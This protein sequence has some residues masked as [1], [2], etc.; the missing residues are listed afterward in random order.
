MSLRQLDSLFRPRSVAVIG[1][2][3]RPGSIGS[4]VMHNMLRGGLPG[5]ILPVNPRYE[6]VSGV[7]AYPGVQE[8]PLVPDLALVCTPPG[9]VPGFVQELG[10]KGTKTA[11][12]MSRDLNRRQD[13]AGRTLQQ[14]VTETAYRHSM[15]I[16]GPDCLG[17]IVPRS[18]LNASFGHTDIAQGKIAFVSQSDA[19]G[20]A[21]LDWAGSKGIGF[22][23]FISLGDCLDVD[24][25]DIIDYLKGDPHSTSILLYMESIR[26]ARRFI[27]AAR[28]ASRNKPLVVIKGDKFSV[29]AGG[30]ASYMDSPVSTD[31]IYD[32]VFR[33]AG[34]LRVFDLAEL[35]D[36]V[37]AMAGYKPLRGDR[38]AILSNGGGPAMMARDV[39]KARGGR[40]AQ[41]SDQTRQ[42]LQQGLQAELSH[43]E[44]VRIID[45]ASSETYSR[46]LEVLIQDQSVDAIMV[47][48][49][50][51]AFACSQ[52]IA[53]AVINSLGRTRKNV[54]AVWLGEKDAAQARRMFALAGI[55]TYE[56]PDQAAR[57]F[58]DMVR[59]R[60]N[61]ELLMETPD[62]VP[63]EFIP[64]SR[65]AGTIVRNALDENRNCLSAPETNEVLSIYNIPVVATRQAADAQE[66]SLISRE[67]GFPLALKI[68]SPDI[69][70]KKHSGALALDLETSGDVLKAARA[71]Q[72][73][74]AAGC[75]E[76]SL[77]GFIVQKMVRRPTAHELTAGVIQ[78]PVFGPAI[79]FGLGNTA[80]KIFNDVAVGLP[81]LNMALAGEIIKQTRISGLLAGRGNRPAI[82]MQ[83]VRLILVQL[84]HLVIDLPEIQEVILKTIL[85]DAG[86]AVV[87]DARIS[88]ASA[89]FAGE[90]RL[91]IRPYPGYLEEH[92]ELSPG[93]RLI[94]RPIRPEDER[95]H[96][97]FVESLTAEDL[98]LRFMGFVHEF[99][100]AQLAQLTQ[101]DYDR[102]MAFIASALEGEAHRET[103]GVVR[104]YFDPDNIS[105][106][107]AIVV[108]SD[109]KGRG[110]GTLL[111]D[112]MIRYCRHRG[113][114]ELTAYALRENTG[115]HAL[116]EKFG[117][118]MEKDPEDPE[119]I[120]LKLDLNQQQAVKSGPA[121]IVRN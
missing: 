40:I 106:E 70:D 86:G 29:S 42:H 110:L 5:P 101:I 21:V 32:G 52:D 25:G 109:L 6:S 65:A 34:M 117:F 4:V 3:N 67:L 85:A 2:S 28:S 98:R 111:M 24:F 118:R 35:F 30:D 116:A 45:H 33:R 7:L 88:I 96:Q 56:T 19:L 84:S 91:S 9:T 120:L 79:F 66:A 13:E 105:G 8:L 90:K 62:S 76:A 64:D 15:R 59:Y 93:L 39:L 51:T 41:L 53:G 103:L 71:M 108:R 87:L 74:L 78:D 104:C 1:A 22:S 72:A 12:I 77:D 83:A 50:P 49:V 38:L 54:I 80:G 26:N 95:S 43:Q 113:L 68:S 94:I 36:A 57:L 119:T 102:E 100:H 73:R 17:I 63:D 14:S 107:F 114:Q 37:E 60:R 46:A 48:H 11:V 61:Q 18:G 75:P 99:S 55:P 58:M 89:G 97:D 81:P 23:H 47:I 10:V 20:T 27:S 69:Q 121:G 31:D 44:P 115:M 82:D 92:A 112:K 16:L